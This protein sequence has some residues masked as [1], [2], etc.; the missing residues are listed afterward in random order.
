MRFL[1][2]VSIQTF[3][4]RLKF[5]GSVGFVFPPFLSNMGLNKAPKVYNN[6]DGWFLS[7]L[8]IQGGLQETKEQHKSQL[9]KLFLIVN[10]NL[11]EN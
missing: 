10:P 1:K 2:H 6:L 9:V 7:P 3:D 4:D 8:K 11:G 5:K